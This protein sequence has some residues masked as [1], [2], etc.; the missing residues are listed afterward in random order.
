[1]STVEERACPSAVDLL[2]YITD[3]L[4]SDY[5][6]WVGGHVGYC[7]T[8]SGVLE[9][10]RASSSSS[11]SGPSGA[12]TRYAVPEEIQRLSA[13]RTVWLADM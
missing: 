2:E 10:L 1:M 7:K 12:H 5:A 13:Q 3:Q 9:G 8:C 4:A 6:K 11:H